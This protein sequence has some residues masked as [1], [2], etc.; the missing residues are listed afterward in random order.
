MT[1]RFGGK[2]P[3]GLGLLITALLTIVTPFAARYGKECLVVLRIIQG[4]AGVSD[5]THYICS[6]SNVN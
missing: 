5:D 3:F 6:G 1:H 2:W 4:L